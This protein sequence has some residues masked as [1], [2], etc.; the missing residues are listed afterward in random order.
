MQENYSD[1]LDQALTDMKNTGSLSS[2]TKS[3]SENSVQLS[4]DLEIA[5]MLSSVPK[6]PLLAG[7]MRR[8]YILASGS[9]SAIARTFNILKITFASAGSLAVLGS[10]VFAGVLSAN[11]LPGQTL[12]KV[13]KVGEQAR[14]KL[15]FNDVEKA[16][17]Q[18]ALSEKR[19]T[20]AQQVL[21]NTS[22]PSA[23]I[24]ALNELS[25]QNT[26]T[27]ESVKKA[28]VT[29]AIQKT[30]HPLVAS[31][32]DLAKK[33]Q[34]FA[35][36]IKPE[37]KAKTLAISTAQQSKKNTAEINNLIEI[38]GASNSSLTIT[39]ISTDKSIVS[40]L[41]TVSKVGKDYITVEGLNFIVNEET[42]IK[43]EANVILTLENIKEKTQVT[44]T[45][46]KTAP[47]NGLIIASEIIVAVKNENGKVEG[48]S[49]STP[50][51]T[52]T[53]AT[54]T[55][56]VKPEIPTSTEKLNDPNVAT[57]SFILEDPTV[58]R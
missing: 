18:I 56:L 49:T 51:S 55:P 3:L 37:D 24:T 8:K 10:I 47:E 4:S 33:Q 32:N 14:L 7:T 23:E 43:N 28:A 6:N 45:G 44:V 40:I 9:N 22:D 46:K 25:S 30:D 36:Q 21:S 42:V 34:A 39:K 57:G 11:S 31:F 1:I 29:G 50:V 17:L 35:S 41:G 48:V 53:K 38:A 54:S 27:A 12:F 16:N 58:L 15:T 13:K 52:P 5:H 19:L 2:A 26:A 20:E